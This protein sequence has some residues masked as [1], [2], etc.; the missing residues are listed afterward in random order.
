MP[1]AGSVTGDRTGRRLRSRTGSEGPRPPRAAR[2]LRAPGQARPFPAR[3]VERGHR[4]RGKVLTHH[5]PVPAPPARRSPA[6]HRRGH[7]APPCRVT[8]GPPP[9]AAAARA[10]RAAAAAANHGP[11]SAGR[12]QWESA[13]SS[14]RAAGPAHRPV[15]EGPERGAGRGPGPLRGTS[16][17]RWDTLP[18][19]PPLPGRRFFPALLACACPLPL[20]LPA[21][22]PGEEAW[23]KRGRDGAPAFWRTQL[24]L[25]PRG[26]RRSRLALFCRAR[27][28]RVGACWGLE[29]DDL[30]GPLPTQTIS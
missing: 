23:L 14:L 24:V 5:P 22:L 15:T 9:P 19:C 30:Q 29:L 10:P 13:A 27:Q 12:S 4:C 7:A 6:H 25:R 26:E 17:G 21:L 1:A 28:I 20:R 3:P 8:S 2:L 16:L 11:R 18:R